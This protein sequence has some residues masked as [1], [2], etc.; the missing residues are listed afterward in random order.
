MFISSHNYFNLEFPFKS[1]LSQYGKNKD[2]YYAS[3]LTKCESVCTTQLAALEWLERHVRMFR[4]GKQKFFADASN[5][6]RLSITD[7]DLARFTRNLLAS[8]TVNL[9]NTSPHMHLTHRNSITNKAL[10]PKRARYNSIINSIMKIRSDPLCLL[11]RKTPLSFLG[12]CAA[13]MAT[14]RDIMGSPITS[15]KALRLT[16]FQCSRGLRKTQ[17]DSHNLT[18]GEVTWP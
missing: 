4:P 11:Y 6:A 13:T 8:T 9:C 12:Y 17:R 15:S 16:P 2:I 14:K 18:I 1:L 5:L 3:F 10:S 7:A